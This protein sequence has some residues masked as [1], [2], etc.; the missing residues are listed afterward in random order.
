MQNHIIKQ[1]KESLKNYKFLKSI[2]DNGNNQ[3]IN[4]IKKIDKALS[5][6]TS[7]EQDIIK[8]KYIEFNKWIVISNQYDYSIRTCQ[9]IAKSGLLKMSSLYSLHS[10]QKVVI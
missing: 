2:A 7:K 10:S 4:I 3:A 9:R 6:L 8:L 1:I 5:L